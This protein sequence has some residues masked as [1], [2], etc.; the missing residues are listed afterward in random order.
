[1]LFSVLFIHLRL[2]SFSANP[3][4]MAFHRPTNPKPKPRSQILF[5]TLAIAAIALLYLF[6][7]LMSTSGFSFSS[8]SKTLNMVFNPNNRN[9]HERIHKGHEKYLYWGD[10]ID[11]P[12]K[13]CDSCEGLGHQE[14][15]LRCAL[16]E[17]M[18]LKRCVLLSVLVL[19]FVFVLCLIAG[20][21]VLC[22]V[23]FLRKC[24]KRDCY[25]V[26]KHTFAKIF[27]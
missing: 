5:F 19:G 20:F 3:M 9:G 7:T 18:F 26:G 23:W 8:S 2:L 21:G 4:P 15:S 24:G 13:H 10:R 27:F 17:A 11:C 22:P 6:S 14:S 1:M 12:G 25:D 16:E